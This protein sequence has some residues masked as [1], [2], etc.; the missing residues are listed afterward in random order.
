MRYTVN[1]AGG[2]TS[3]YKEGTEILHR[4]DGPAVECS[5]GARYW[6][7]NDIQHREG[8]PAVVYPDGTES[9]YVNGALHREDGPAAIGS[10]GTKCWFVNGALHREDGP[11]VERANGTKMWYLN[12]AN[13]SEQEF[14]KRTAPAKELTV[15]EIEQL[16]GHR[17][18]VVK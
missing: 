12:G 3:W 17:V 13:V 14:L 11:A 9:W 6:Y 5:T 16:L 10:D 4:E 15:A 7:I 1:V 2:V 18:K 8:G